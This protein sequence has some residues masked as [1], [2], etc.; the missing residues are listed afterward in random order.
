MVNASSPRGSWVLG[1]RR[2][3][4]GAIR[5]GGEDI[6]MRPTRGILRDGVACIPDA[7]L[8]MGVA[9]GR[10]VKENFILSGWQC[11]APVARS[12]AVVN[13]A[14]LRFTSSAIHRAWWFK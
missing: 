10:T 2:C 11:T 4:S 3:T 9:P 12:Q 14:P 13:A 8:A 5:L 1:L 6:S 7:L